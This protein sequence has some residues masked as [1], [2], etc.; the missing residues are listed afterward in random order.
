MPRL[1]RSALRCAPLFLS[2]LLMSSAHAA[3]P[4]KCR[5]SL[6]SKLPLQYHGNSM[7]IAMEGKINDTPAVMLIDTGASITM[8]TRFA[9]DK[10]A[11]RREPTLSSVTGVGG[12]TRLFQAPI[13]SIEL[14]AIK[15]PGGGSLP[16]IDE[17]G[18]R[19][20]FDALIGSDFLLDMDVELALAD[21]Q[22]RFF[23]PRNCETTFLG[24]WNP[25]AVEVPMLF[26][27][28]HKRPMVDVLLNGVKLRALIDSGATMSAISVKGA[29][30]AGVTPD[31]AGVV[32]G[33]D[34]TGIGQR[35]V[36]MYQAPFKTFAIGEETIQN[37]VLQIFDHQS[38]EFDVILGTDFLRA[39][40][41]LFAPS[42]MKIY[43][44]YI[45]GT[46]PFNDGRTAPWIDRE[47]EA[48]N[49]YAQFNVASGL[50]RSGNPASVAR[51]EA[52]LTK[53]VASNN[54]DALRYLARQ[55]T[56][57][58]RYADS[59]DLFERLV[60]QDPFDMNA[61]MEL[62]VAR[63]R[64]GQSEAAGTALAAQMGKFRWAP[65]PRQ[66]TEY[67]LGKMT[68]DK[69]LAEAADDKD[70]ATRRRC[71]VY[72]HVGALQEALGQPLTLKDKAA[73]EC[74]PGRKL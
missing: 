69:L 16:V 53:S 65:W 11:L 20:S 27:L 5:Y 9:T 73:T 38:S 42:Q 19:P 68:L 66:I 18:E 58:K 34:A 41:I 71:E 39:H 62:Y 35:K 45:D 4:V 26:E 31:S 13:K 24:Y 30:L 50:L 64:A 25:A 48:G 10:R 54:P 51:G 36:K 2:L 49:S 12:S 17:T 72:F 15:A 47:A 7:S 57:E 37:A 43:L 52:L 67:Y 70:M 63:V 55:R 61:Q 14:G 46:A 60:Q 3:E 32:A 28:R 59:V 40:R 6:L 56:G 44:S 33:Q 29:K 22:I 74:P 8:L 1:S 21:K 23:S